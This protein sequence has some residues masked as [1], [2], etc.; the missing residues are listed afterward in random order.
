LWSGVQ[1][2]Q[3]EEPYRKFQVDMGW[4]FQDH[5]VILSTR[6]IDGSRRQ[7]RVCKQSGS[8]LRRFFKSAWVISR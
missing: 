8:S 7:T 6:G 3:R 5:D 2:A 1:A 4:M